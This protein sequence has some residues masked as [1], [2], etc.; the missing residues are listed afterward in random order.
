[1]I[2]YDGVKLEVSDNWSATV[3]RLTAPRI[4]VGLAP[5]LNMAD[6]KVRYTSGHSKRVYSIDVPKMVIWIQNTKATTE[7]ITNIENAGANDVTKENEPSLMAQLTQNSIIVETPHVRHVANPHFEGW[8]KTCVFIDGAFLYRTVNAI[9][10]DIDYKRL[11]EFFRNRC[12]LVRIYY[13][14]ALDPNKETNLYRLVDWLQY[15]GYYVHVQEIIEYMEGK[16]TSQD[17]SMP[18]ALD[19]FDMAD[20]M[21]HL[22][23]CGGVPQ[24]S[25]LIKRSRDKGAIVTLF[26]SIQTPTARVNDML[27]READQFM[28]IASIKNDVAIQG[29][30][31]A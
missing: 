8:Q 16:F 7:P 17:V 11:L 31:A 14:I 22:V 28:E 24:L 12:N 30:I 18:L 10:F 21:D 19:M 15:N 3:G 13:Y 23:I 4:I 25:G 26:G 6:A 29:K 2:E 5:N 1:M 9:G 20:K 27:R